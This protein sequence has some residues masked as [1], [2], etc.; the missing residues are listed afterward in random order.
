[1]FTKIQTPQEPEVN[2]FIN[3]CVFLPSIV[4]GNIAQAQNKL[5]D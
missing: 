2:G 4:H 3:L 1:M 5:F